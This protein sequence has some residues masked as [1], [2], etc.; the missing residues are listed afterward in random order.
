MAKV[1]TPLVDIDTSGE[2]GAVE[3]APVEAA[4][5]A[6]APAPA[7]AAPAAPATPAPTTAAA[8]APASHSSSD[9]DYTLA[10]P[11]VRRIAKENHIDLSKV[12]GTGKDGRVLKEDV[13]AYLEAAKKPAAVAP[14]AAA[15]TPTPAPAVHVP[16]P[17]VH[18][19]PAVDT[20]VPLTPIQKAMYK[21]MTKS[22]SI[23]H[24][25]FS[26]EIYMDACSDLRD[27]INKRLKAIYKSKGGDGKDAKEGVKKITYMPILLKAMS[28]ALRDY[29][30]LNAGLVQEGEKVFIKYRGDHN[31]GVAMDTPQGLLVPNVK[32]V[33]TKSILEIASDLERL[34][35]LASRGALTPTDL[36]NGTITLSNIGNIG[37]TALHP[38][39]VPGEVCIGAI[40]RIQRVPRFEDVEGED[41]RKEER[42]VPRQ[43]MVVNF[44]A[45]HRVIDGATVA[46][47]VRAW[48]TH[49]EDP[50]GMLVEMR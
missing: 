24:F 41:G 38:V 2:G 10:T 3:S 49:L 28:L 21:Q 48:R 29:P 20:L 30:I 34:K 13:L 8:P 14:A 32:S 9:Y 43:V 19:A 15:P 6:E 4:A 25:G 45:D 27:T 46:R 1:G 40:G 47:F 26:D 31:I 36:S 11:A 5:P 50:V 7:P 33:N 37:G 42:V 23:P 18:V 16:A 39:I 22:L 12:K 44:N 35:H 17:A